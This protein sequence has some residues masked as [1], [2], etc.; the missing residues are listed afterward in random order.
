MATCFLRL[1]TLVLESFILF[2]YVAL[3]KD[4]KINI[5]DV[6]NQWW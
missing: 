1:N 5:K 3:M 4:L 2:R 6:F